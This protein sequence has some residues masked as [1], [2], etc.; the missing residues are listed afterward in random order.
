MFHVKQSFLIIINALKKQRFY[1]MISAVEKWAERG[2]TMRLS[3]LRL[4]QYRNYAALDFKPRPGVNVIVGDNAQGKTNAAEAIF[5]CA[6][7]RSHRTPR[8][9]ELIAR[10]CE[11]GYVG[12]EIES[13]CGTHLIE[14]K[15]RDGE[16]KKIFINRQ[17]AGRTGE[18]MGVVNVVMFAPEDLFLVKEGPAERRRFLDMELSQARPAYYYRLQQYNA[19][20][21]QRNALLKSDAIRPG[22]LAMWDEQLSTLGEAIMAERERFVDSLSTI[23]YDLHKSITGGRE[24][25]S[26]FYQPNVSTDAPQGVREAL[27]QALTEGAAEDMRRGFTQCGPHRDDMAIRLGDIDLR[28]F[29]SQGQQRTAALSIKLSELALLREEK[30]ESPILLLDDV[31]SELDQ[32]RQRLLLQSVK[33][34]Q[35]FLTCTSL[36]GLEKA[37]MGESALW[38]CQAGAIAPLG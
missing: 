17:M 14:I 8:D 4:N 16:R 33:G 5:L 30:G 24:R 32:S 12:A 20:L 25:L 26:I 21:R 27:L 38:K 13:L 18:L 11:G 6:L 31:L 28:A 37:D 34:C 36:D 2:K 7:G 19:A 10:G 15:L 22:M 9:G 29:G 1:G 3:R 35:C 23:A